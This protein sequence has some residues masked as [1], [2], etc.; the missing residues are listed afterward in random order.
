MK[1][2][3]SPPFTKEEIVKSTL[4]NPQIITT[5]AVISALQAHQAIK[6]LHKLKG[7]KSI[8]EP[9]R[10]YVLYNAITLQFLPM[11]I[12]RNPDCSICGDNVK[13]VNIKIKKNARCEGIIQSLINMGFELDPNMEHPKLSFMDF[14][15]EREI[16]LDN[17]PIQN[18]L[19][20]DELI[21]AGGFIGGDIF[22]NLILE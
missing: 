16:N 3:F 18:E 12:K 14:E 7:N 6:I 5:I 13:R 8:G 21:I 1:Y 10:S 19:R 15:G 2:S 9:I 4:R 22:I 17:T 11:E 20:N